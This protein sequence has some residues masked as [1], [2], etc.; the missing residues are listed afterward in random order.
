VSNFGVLNPRHAARQLRVA[1]AGFLLAYLITVSPHLVRHAFEPDPTATAQQHH[2]TQHHDHS[3]QQHDS[4]RPA[5]PLLLLSQQTHTDLQEDLCPI[6]PPALASMLATRQAPM[7][8][9]LLL[10]PRLQPR[11]PPRLV[12][13]N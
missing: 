3:P 5:C 7:M 10:Q 1:L 4:S 12:A 6:G 2:H 13:S 11:A 9:P 8:V